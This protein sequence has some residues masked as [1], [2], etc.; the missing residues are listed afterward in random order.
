MCK[1]K[2][3]M[4]ICFPPLFR[5]RFSPAIPNNIPNNWWFSSG[6]LINRYIPGSHPTDSDPVVLGWLNNIYFQKISS[7]ADADGSWTT[8]PALL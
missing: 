4:E 2:R 6:K 7:E 5:K 3:R 8:L 1:N